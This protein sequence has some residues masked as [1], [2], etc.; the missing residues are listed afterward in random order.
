[1][2]GEKMQAFRL[3][4]DTG[5]T[6]SDFCVLNQESGDL[7]SIKVP[8]TPQDPSQAVITGVRQLLEMGVHPEDLVSFSHGTT[9]GTNALL[10]E[11]GSQVGVLLTDGLRGSNDIY[12]GS[13]LS[14]G[15]FELYRVLPKW[16]VSP[17]FCL[18]VKERVDFRGNVIE[19]L[20]KTQAKEAILRLKEKG[21]ESLAVCLLFSFMNPDHEQELARLI[22]EIH[23][24]CFIS[25]SSE[26]LPQIRERT[27]LSTTIVNAMIGPVLKKFLLGLEQML[28]QE[29]VKT[30]QMYVMQCN[31]G[32][33]TF[34][35]GAARAV[36]LVLSGPAAGILGVG[37]LAG[38]AGFTNV[39]GMDMGGTSC[40]IGLVKDGEVLQ[41]IK[42][43]VGKWDIA[44][45]MLDVSTISAGGGTIARVGSSG[46]LVLGPESAGADPGPVCY[47]KGGLWPTITDANLVLGFLSPDYLL[48]GKMKL[49]KEKA[50][51]VIQDKIA[52]PLGLSLLEAAHGIIRIVNADMEQGIRAVSAEKG[53]DLRDFVLF[54]FGG[55]GPIHAAGLAVALNIP[56]VMVPLTPGVIS[57]LG[58][59]LADVRHDYVRSYLCPFVALEPEMVNRQ[60]REL[61]EKAK[62]ELIA[63]GFS[64][65]E[66]Q[67]NCFLDM[68]YSGQGYE[69]TVP[70]PSLHFT[71]STLELMRTRFDSQHERLFGHKAETQPVEVVSYRLVSLIDVPK[72]NLKRYAPATTG[73]EVALKA[74]REVYFGHDEGSLLSHIYSREDLYPGHGIKGPAIVEQM[75]STTVIYPGQRADIDSYRNIIISVG[76]G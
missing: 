38:L 23:P 42:A 1:M 33:S 21:V 52:G 59:L 14:Q 36:P 24:D 7:I 49:D 16:L 68:R 37:K 63:D 10:E 32:V 71:K 8:S 22:R 12:T 51:Q 40:D 18:G 17:R 54:A 53:Y 3:G 6:F 26:V 13:A 27:R 55:A 58:L 61:A 57:A 56:K 50:Q 39:I 2:V 31:G 48:A 46:N 73:V 75:D 72:P 35:V 66:I 19:P 64:K 30:K 29:G 76:E 45:P 41:T 65:K 43:S 28:R 60:F 9:V 5:G 11:K 25:L 62:A 4:V 34:A 70:A 69:I 47:G 44:I 74:E 67:I 15:I 20:D